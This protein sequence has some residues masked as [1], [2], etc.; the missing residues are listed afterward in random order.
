MICEYDRGRVEEKS[1]LPVV[2][3]G[4]QIWAKNPLKIRRIISKYF[5]TLSDILFRAQVILK[6]I[7]WVAADGNKNSV[8]VAVY[9]E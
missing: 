5:N 9:F 2:K 1:F 7:L 6:R 3:L 4:L 8:M